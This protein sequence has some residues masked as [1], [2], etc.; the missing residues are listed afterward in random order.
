MQELEFVDDSL[1]VLPK[2]VTRYQYTMLIANRAKD[3]TK[4]DPPRINAEGN[5]DVYD[6]AAKELKAQV[7]PLRLVI[8]LPNGKERICNPNE[9]NIRDY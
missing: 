6:I 5:Y 2:F 4:G 3:L 1:C 8:T 7:L 9:M